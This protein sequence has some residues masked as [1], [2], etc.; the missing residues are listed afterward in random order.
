MNRRITVRDGETSRDW[1][2][3]RPT[4]R[5][6]AADMPAAIGQENAATEAGETPAQ[7]G[8]SRLSPKTDSR[9]GPAAKDEQMTNPTP[10][11]TPGNREANATPIRR[12]GEP[13]TTGTPRSG[14][15]PTCNGMAATARDRAA[16]RGSR[17]PNRIC[18]LAA[19]G[20]RQPAHPKPAGL[21]GMERER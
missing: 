16:R 5:A 7:H 18:G 4:E 15:E 12:A 8:T 20:Q 11:R 6:T 14:N 1:E 10:S 19:G 9:P 3:S 2:V 17:L 13:R 21:V